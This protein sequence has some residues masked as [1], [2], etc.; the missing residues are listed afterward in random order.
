MPIRAVD[1]VHS[2]HAADLRSFRLHLLAYW[3]AV[4]HLAD[5]NRR[6]LRRLTRFSISLAFGSSG[7]RSGFVLYCNG[8]LPGWKCFRANISMLFFLIVSS[9]RWPP[10]DIALSIS[11]AN[12]SNCSWSADAIPMRTLNTSESSCCSSCSGLQTSWKSWNEETWEA[13]EIERA[14]FATATD[15]DGSVIARIDM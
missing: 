5:A 6:I 7:R 12:R 14:N 2:L 3:S 4:R 11:S 8:G 13:V 9:R 10:S 1:S 15:A